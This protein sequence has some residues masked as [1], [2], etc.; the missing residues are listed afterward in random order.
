MR[1][2]QGNRYD[3]LRAGDAVRRSPNQALAAL[4]AARD[5]LVRLFVHPRYGQGG[6]GRRYGPRFRR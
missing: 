3:A 1:I 2:G 4:Q 5:G 6:G